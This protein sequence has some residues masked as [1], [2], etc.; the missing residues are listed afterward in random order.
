MNLTEQRTNN[1]QDVPEHQTGMTSSIG[2][3]WPPEP[4]SFNRI[5][6]FY[7]HQIISEREELENLVQTLES[8][9]KR[10]FSSNN[11]ITRISF[12][13]IVDS[14]LLRKSADI[15]APCI[16]AIIPLNGTQD[17]FNNSYVTYLGLNHSSRSP[18][19]DEINQYRRNLEVVINTTPL[20]SPQEIF[21]RINNKGY[22]IRAI[23]FLEE[24]TNEREVTINQVATLYN[25]FGWNR[26]DVIALL[27]NPSNIIAVANI[28]QQIVSAGI[29]ELGKVQVGSHTLRIAEI[30]E[31]AT[32]E[33]HGKNGLYTAV[34][35]HLLK[36]LVRISKINGIF[37]GEIDYAFGECN[38]NA[39]GVLKTAK[40][41]GRNFAT[42]F[43]LDLGFPERGILY[44]H[45][46]IGGSPRKTKYN[47]LFPAF[48]NRR[49]L[50]EKWNP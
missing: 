31:A 20:K 15:L 2:G 26:N 5:K 41:Q 40:I 16:E 44:Q 27:S 50:Y 3:L 45:V 4:A 19:S 17:A 1:Q 43:M 47:D 48:I 13:A 12:R 6:G 24:N 33:E 37:N 18:N 49:R 14:D 7:T 28:N 23:N 25:R 22:N 34:S 39:P 46:P 10:N 29:A 36:E 8:E 30:T 21:A 35:S 11:G 32:L 9:S 38:A 42:E